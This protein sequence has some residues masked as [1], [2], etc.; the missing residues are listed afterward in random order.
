MNRDEA[1]KTGGIHLRL[2]FL[3]PAGRVSCPPSITWWYYLHMPLISMCGWARMDHMDQTFLS[4]LFLRQYLE[5]ISCLFSLL[6][7]QNIMLCPYYFLDPLTWSDTLLLYSWAHVIH[8]IHWTHFLVLLIIFSFVYILF[9]QLYYKTR[10]KFFSIHFIFLS[11]H[12]LSLLSSF[13]SASF[14]SLFF[15]FSYGLLFRP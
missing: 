13:L 4:L 11:F 9:L 14:L 1:S 8:A 5:H 12:P 3:L 2:Y 7:T 15:F 6:S 10:G